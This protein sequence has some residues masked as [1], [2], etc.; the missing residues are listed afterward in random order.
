IM[1]MHRGTIAILNSKNIQITISAAYGLSEEEISKGIY[2]PGEGITGR[3]VKSGKPI[4]IPDISQDPAFL[5]KTGS[6]KES[7]QRGIAFVCVP[8]KIESQVIGTLSVDRLFADNISLDEDL[9]LLSIVASMI[10]QSVKQ[11][12]HLKEEKQQLQQ[13]A[14]RLQRQLKDRFQPD[15]I[16]GNSQAMHEV[17]DLI[18]QVSKSE[19]TVFIRG[20]SGTGK[21][22]VAQ[23]IHFNSLRADK[24][25]IKVNCAALPESIIESEL[26]GHEKGAFTGAEN[27]RKGRFELA[28][29][30]TIFLDEIG[31]LSPMTQVKLLR[32]LQEREIER[33]GGTETIKINVRVLTATNRVLEQ[34]IEKGVFRE[35][36]YYRLNVFPI[37]LPPLKERK[38]DIILLADHFIEKNNLRNHKSVKRISSPAIDLLMSYHW[39]G[40]VRELE[41]CIERAVLLSSDQVIHSYHLP[42]SLQSAESSNTKMKLTLK[43]AVEKLEEEMIRETLKIAKGNRAKAAREL[44]ITERIMGLRVDKYGIST[45]NYKENI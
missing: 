20:E 19:A 11:M 31:E 3:V 23:A 37:H 27:T 34:E 40:N 22:L 5:D 39:P 29:G 33:V 36:L 6:R 35:D 4:A 24:P 13:E 21:E 32:V 45:Y 15:N 8:L 25:F 7:N 38:S 2:Q 9:R 28:N 14:Q 43:D 10:S 12:Q 30:G 17:Y 41:N 44:G 42:P 26:F 16:I 18:Q 1:G